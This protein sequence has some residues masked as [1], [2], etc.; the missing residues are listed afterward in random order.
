MEVILDSSLGRQSV[1]IPPHRIEYI[2]SSHALVSD[3]YVCVRV[4][5]NVTDMQRTGDGW[6]GGINRKGLFAWTA[7]VVAVDRV[8]FPLCVPS[9]FRFG[10]VEVFGHFRWIDGPERRIV[11]HVAY[12]L[13]KDLCLQGGTWPRRSIL[14]IRKGDQWLPLAGEELQQGCCRVVPCHQ[15]L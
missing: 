9:S 8:S 12:L 11:A 13:V 3:D 5:K 10:S 1:V 15:R 7:G 2:K 14:L 4:A 6:R